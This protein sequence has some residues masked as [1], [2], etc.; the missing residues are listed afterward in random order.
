ML[1]R[2]SLV[3][4]EAARDHVL[5]LEDIDLPRGDW[6]SGNLDLYAAFGAPGPPLA[7]DAALV[8]LVPEERD[9]RSYSPEE[10]VATR[11]STRRSPGTSLLLGQSHMAG[12]VLHVAER[13]LRRAYASGD[14]AVLRIRTLVRAPTAD[15]TGA[16]DVV[17]RLGIAGGLP[18]T[19]GKIQVVSAEPTARIVNAEATLCGS[20][21]DGWPLAVVGAGL[22]GAFADRPRQAPLEPSAAVRHP[23]DDLHVRWWTDPPQ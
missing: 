6:Q 8:G 10:R 17:V 11:T 9:S 21:A 23:G 18:M 20:E 3:R 14:R 16:R 4:V 19:L 1:P 12:V 7:V 15:A 5:I 22:S 13:Q 2:V